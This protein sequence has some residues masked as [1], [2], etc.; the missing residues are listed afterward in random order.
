M[1]PHVI[2]RVVLKQFCVHTESECKNCSVLVMDKNTSIYRERGVNHKTFVGPLNY[3]GNG[4]PG[5]LE[6]EMACKDESSLNTIIKILSKEFD[7]SKYQ[8]DLKYLLGNN[9]ARNPHFRCHPK[10]SQR[11]DLSSEIF[12]SYMMDIFAECYDDLPV[13]VVRLTADSNLFVL[14]DFSLTHMVISPK[15]AIMRVKEKDRVHFERIAKEDE[16]SFARSLNSVSERE[17]VSW[18]VSNSRELLNL[19]G[20]IPYKC[21]DVA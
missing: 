1:K 6:N 3:L 20:G 2:P 8:Q 14:P 10:V 13:S 4:E 16:E 18:I 9:T 7:L 12:H 21:C 15:I 11:N 5:T 17:S 19:M